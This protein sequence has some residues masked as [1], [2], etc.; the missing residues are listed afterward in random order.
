MILV[1]KDATIPAKLSGDGQTENSHNKAAYDAHRQDYIDDKKQFSIKPEIYN[2]PGIKE[3]LKKA[4]HGKCCFCEKE[5]TDEYGA[6]EHYRPKGGYQVA[7]KTKLIKP[8]YYW[9]GYEWSNLYFVC[10]PCNTCKANI[11]PLVDETKR[12]VSHHDDITQEEPYLLDP[13]GTKDPRDHIVFDF[14][15][16][17]GKTIYGKETIDACGLNRD[18]LNEKRKKLISNME[19]HIDI[20]VLQDIHPAATVEKSRK[21]LRSCCLPQADFSAA[22]ADYLKEYNIYHVLFPGASS[23]L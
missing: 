11:F 22:A 9:L 12:A 15:F 10:G 20:I 21:F 23:T 4:Q 1:I 16:V 14:G 5:Q 7:K 3:A 19:L 8:G 18:V 2:Y 6:V 13:A 17:R